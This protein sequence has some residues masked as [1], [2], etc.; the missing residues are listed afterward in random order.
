MQW[1]L[2]EW[3]FFSILQI[4]VNSMTTDRTTLSIH[5]EK[6]MDID[7]RESMR[8]LWQGKLQEVQRRL[9]KQKD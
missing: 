2:A 8:A 6:L 7:T 1:K 9:G 4:R 3:P 5:Q